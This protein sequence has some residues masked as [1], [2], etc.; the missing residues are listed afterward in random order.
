VA[1]IVEAG[2]R[3]LAQRGWAGFTTNEVAR[4]AG[5]S[6]GSLYQYFPDKLAIAETILQQHLAAVLAAM[7][8]PAR[9]DPSLSL[10][11]RVDQLIDGLLT[12]HAGD[13][14]LHRVMLEEVPFGPRIA[15]REFEQAYLRRYEALI[16]AT[17]GS[18]EDAACSLAA[19]MLSGAVEGLVHGA[20]RRGEAQSP[21]V[22]RDATRVVTAYLHARRNP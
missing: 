22:R 6:I 21:I 3:V 15:A 20:V 1:S 5:A 18:C 13:Q 9:Q 16:R 14:P 2:A 4:V 17:D 19:T 8:D 11:R 7:P 10:D 12:V